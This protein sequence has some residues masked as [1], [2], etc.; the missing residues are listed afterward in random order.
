MSA[1]A[2]V[3]RSARLY[4]IHGLLHDYVAAAL[5]ADAG[6][7]RNEWV[8]LAVGR[9]T[10]IQINSGAAGSGAGNCVIDIK[11]NGTSI[12]GSTGDRPTLV[13]TDSGFYT[14]GLDK[15]GNNP[16]FV[17]GDIISWDV[18]SIGAN[19]GPLRTSVDI[20]IGVGR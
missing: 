4:A 11:K 2:V 13:N 15:P 7:P 9:L 12:F 8:M 1:Q 5:A 18:I 10:N 17:E 6:T 16:N 19:S 20:A 14:I 3:K